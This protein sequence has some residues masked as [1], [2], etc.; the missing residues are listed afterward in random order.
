MEIEN[1]KKLAVETELAILD[2]IRDFTNKTGLSVAD[3]D[4][5]YTTQLGNKYMHIPV[6][7]NLTIHI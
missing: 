7:V 4:F 5:I 2:L 3:I 1:A 6:S